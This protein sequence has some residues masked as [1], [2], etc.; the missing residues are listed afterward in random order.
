[1]TD[2]D[3][4]FW[5][6][7]LKTFANASVA[8]AC[9]DLQDGLG[10]D[11]NILLFML[12]CARHRRRLS[13]RDV[14]NVVNLAKG[15]Q[16]DIVRPLRLVRSILKRPAPNWPAIQ[17]RGLRESVK[18]AE[19]EAERLQQEAMAASIPVTEIGL[20][21]TIDAAAAANLKAYAEFARVA[22]PE[23]HVAVLL[24]C[25]AETPHTKSR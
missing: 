7:S 2:S 21:D 10:I 15:W 14:G 17:T 8:H 16:A 11:V 20:P 22:F 12:W 5:T 25:L 24:S 18:A 3:A 13:A 23:S 19:L 4:S 6:F 9:L 1:M